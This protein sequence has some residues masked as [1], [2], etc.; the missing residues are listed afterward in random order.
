LDYRIRSAGD[1]TV[2]AAC[3]IADTRKAHFNAVAAQQTVQYMEQVTTAAEAGAE[4]AQA[5]QTMLT[6]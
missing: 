6:Y 2:S 4:L 1:R 5:A 3:S